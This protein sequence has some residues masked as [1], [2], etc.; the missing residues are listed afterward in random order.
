VVG[1][2]VF[3]DTERSRTFSKGEIDMA[4]AVI[5]QAATALENARLMHD[6][7]LSFQELKNT[8]ERLIQAAR[9]SAMGEL[10]AAVAHQINNPLTTIVTDTELLLLDEPPTSRNYNSLNAVL[11]AGKRAAGVARR[12]LAIARPQDPSAPVD[13]IDVV[14]TL[15][16]VMTLVKSHL[17]RSHIQIVAKIPDVSLPPVMAVPGQLDD[18]WL[19]LLLNAHDALVGRPDGRIIVEVVYTAGRQYLDVIIAD[20]G[21]GIPENVIGEIFKPFFTTK[22]VGEG[23]GLGLHICRQVIERVNGNISV[24]SALEKGTRFVVR[25]PVARV[26]VEI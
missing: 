13:P 8:Q 22:P 16:G 15:K 21:P 17:E 2:V 5:A 14:D 19:N 3:A 11:R 4:R 9:L 25:L 6:L 26:G 23:T 7:A 24:E 18:V 12:L 1:L 20:N 10:A